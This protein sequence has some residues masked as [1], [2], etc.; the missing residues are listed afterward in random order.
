[1]PLTDPDRIARDQQMPRMLR[2][3]RALQPLKSVLRLMNSGAHPDDETSAMLA[4]LGL[5]DGLNLSYICANRGEGGQNDIGTEATEDLGT[6]R[7]AEMELAADV[8]D[9][10]LYWLSDAPDDTIFDFGFSKSGV[11]SMAKWGRDRVLAR[12]VDLVRADRPD[13]LCPTFLDIPGQHGHH[14]AMTEAAHLV[15]DLAADPAFSGSDLPA[16]RISK[17]Y[18]P[19][20]SGAGGSYDDEV[21]PPPA[22]LTVSGQGQEEVSGWS[23]ARIGQQSRCYHKTQG[24]GRW[25]GPGDFAGWPLHLVRSEVGPDEGA[26]SDHLPGRLEDLGD[27][28]E[29][30]TA[31]TAIDAAIAAFPDRPVIL[32]FALA[33]HAALSRARASVATE[34]LHRIDAKLAQLARAIRIASGADPRGWLGTDLLAPGETAALHFE[35]GDAA[36]FALSITPDLPEG[37]QST[38]EGI[39]PGP[40]APP[41][42]PYPDRYDPLSPP[43]PRLAVIVGNIASTIALEVPPLVLPACRAT[44]SKGGV[45]VSL[46]QPGRQVALDISDSSGGVPGFDLPDGWGQIWEGDHARITLPRDLEPGLYDLALTLDGQP[47]ETARILQKAHI[48]PRL[49]SFPARLRIRA[50]EVAIPAARI[51]YVGGGHDRVANWLTALGCDVTVLAPGDLDGAAPFAPFQTVLVGVFALRFRPDLAAR[52]A[53]LHGWTRQGGNLVTLYHRPG[54][55]WD[56]TTTPPAMLEIG[57]P[58]LRWRVT[59]EAAE[60]THLLPDHPLLST[61]N[62]ISAADWEGWHKER[63][64]YFA[65]SW[66]AAYRPILAMADPDEAPH[67]GALLS[68]NI[69]D[70]R[71]SHCALILHH[72]MEKLVP[73]AFRLMANLL[74]PVRSP[75][76]SRTGSPS[77]QTRC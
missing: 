34:H 69:G 77:V 58:S 30:A 32:K 53:D 50:L 63:G 37:W 17:L 40:G 47:A 9:M 24:M 65:K 45:V 74:A 28:P 64:L 57:Q 8:L 67:H 61:P 2:L 10:R 62:I 25:V 36:G 18:L 75:S 59:D 41:A 21:P 29:L 66:D 5:R 26:I 35:A 4:A 23:W 43:R 38:L 49:R 60:V 27:N 19:A 76:A 72:Q 51:A 68:A 39:G 33:A 7:T 73:G 56:A 11:E 52:L 46:A 71:H 48:A 55:N 44:L 31:S 3:W 70:G 6:I 16:W 22:T 42:D 13:I 54:D 1:M 15:M 12:F 14:R 20:W